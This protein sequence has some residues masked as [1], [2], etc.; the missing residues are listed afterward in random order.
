MLDLCM[1]YLMYDSMF[2]SYKTHGQCNYRDVDNR[3][4]RK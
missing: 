2:S 1:H 3:A 4:E